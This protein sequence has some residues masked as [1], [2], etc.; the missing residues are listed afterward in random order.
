[1]SFTRLARLIFVIVDF[2][3]PGIYLLLFVT[4]FPIFASAIRITPPPA[5]WSG[6]LT[7]LCTL[8]AWPILLKFYDNLANPVI[9]H[10]IRIYSSLAIIFFVIYFVIFNLFTFELPTTKERIVLGCGFTENAKLLASLYN[11]ATHDDCPGI[12]ERMLSGATYNVYEIWQKSSIVSLRVAIVLSWGSAY[13]F[14]LCTV[15]LVI[16]GYQPR[17]SYANS[18]ATLRSE[19]HKI[20]KPTATKDYVHPSDVFIAYAHQDKDRVQTI[21]N[22]LS[23]EGLFI[24]WDR[25]V[26]PG[27]T[28][29]EVINYALESAHCVVV[30]W[31]IYSVASDF[32]REEAYRAKRRGVLVPV[33]FDPVALPYGFN[34]VQTANLVGWNGNTTNSEYRS[35]LFSIQNLRLEAA[36]PPEKS[37]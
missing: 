15:G 25:D 27:Q 14:L 23:R 3:S 6:I 13:F 2:R 37:G 35:L 4:I 18:P 21:I 26:T 16:L 1:M 36:S 9:L 12:Y 24:W 20:R 33:L 28:W 19:P 29:D 11:I 17:L 32:V 34:L 8:I 10:L 22:A 30:V 5:R 7:A 31:S